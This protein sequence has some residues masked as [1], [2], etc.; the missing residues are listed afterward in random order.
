LVSNQE[1]SRYHKKGTES[2]GGSVK[3]QEKSS[4]KSTSSELPDFQPTR[5]CKII[6]YVVRQSFSQQQKSMDFYPL[7][8]L[9]IFENGFSQACIYTTEIAITI[10]FIILL[11]SSVCF[12]TLS[13]NFA[14][15]LPFNTMKIRNNVSNKITILLINNESCKFIKITLSWHN[16]QNEANSCQGGDAHFFPQNIKKND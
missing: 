12:A 1:V 15:S 14:A 2:C 11:R 13:R 16:E 4:E 5:D 3:R 10:S 9:M 7:I 8:A 6:K